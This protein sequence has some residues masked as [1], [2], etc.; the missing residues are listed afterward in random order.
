MHVLI[1]SSSGHGFN[2][3]PRPITLSAW[4]LNPF[5][6]RAWVQHL[7]DLECG[8]TRSLNPFF[9]RAWVQPS[10]RA[11]RNPAQCLNPFFIRAWVQPRRRPPAPRRGVLI[12]SSSGHGFNGSGHFFLF[13]Q[14]VAG[15][16]VLHLA[17]GE[18][19]HFLEGSLHY[20]THC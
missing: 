5:F 2:A 6:I 12:P 7:E 17:A 16:D 18:A 13:N 8:K 4:G 15:R 11:R 3:E 9:I 10:R 20:P 19:D 14:R 1:P